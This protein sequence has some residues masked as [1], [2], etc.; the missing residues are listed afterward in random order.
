[1]KK[2]LRPLSNL[3]HS[4]HSNANGLT[5]SGS[6][7]QRSYRSATHFCL[8]D[9]WPIYVATVLAMAITVLVS[10]VTKTPLEIFLRDPSATFGENPLVGMQSSLG[11]LVWFSGGAVCLFCAFAL[12]YLSAEPAAIRPPSADCRKSIAFFLSFGLFSLYL[13]L[14][15]LFVVHEYVADVFLEISQL[16]LYG[17]YLAIAIWLLLQFHRQ[18]R[19]SQ[20]WGLLAIAIAFFALSV[21]TDIFQDY[22][23]S[24]WRMFFEDGC[25][26][27]GIVSWSGYFFYAGIEALSHYTSRVD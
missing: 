20:M 27:L 14:D 4:S 22:W 5:A 26:L 18:I 21:V 12:R 7:L 13:S 23:I 10:R 16:P 19:Q 9:S 6:V 25:K 17:I 2:E 15:D 1:M 8:F 24:R 3:S 11:V